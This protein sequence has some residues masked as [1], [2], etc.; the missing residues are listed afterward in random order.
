MSDSGS[1][2]MMVIDS[3]ETM[4]VVARDIVT[5]YCIDHGIDEKDIYPTVW[6][7]IISELYIKLF[8]PF[9]YLLKTNTNRYNEYDKDKVLYVYDNIYKRLCNTHC[10]EVYLKAF[11]DMVGIDKQTIYNWQAS[12]TKSFDLQQ[13]IQD[14]NE[15]SLFAL[16]K[17]RRNNPMK[18]L[19]KLNRYHT[20]NMPGVRQNADA[21]K[22][23]SVA[24]LP[25][26]FPENVQN[27]QI[28][29]SGDDTESGKPQDLVLKKDLTQDI[30]T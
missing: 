4:A 12:S 29:F 19:P 24:D 11:C 21:T 27:T 8:R 6:N 3:V 13:K 10:Q 18:Y 2:D 22:S 25:K 7:D 9:N 28:E 1:D 30:D 23:L 14:D 15:E 17:D 16:M 26:L 20:W 5:S